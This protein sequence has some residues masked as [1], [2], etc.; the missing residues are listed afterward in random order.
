MKS[1]ILTLS[2]IFFPDHA[3]C[4][5]ATSVIEISLSSPHPETYRIE[6][7]SKEDY[8]LT[9]HVPWQNDLSKLISKK[10]VDYV[11]N[12]V[13]QIIWLSNYKS[14]ASQNCSEYASLVSGAD[15]ARVCTQNTKATARTYGLVA[16]LKKFK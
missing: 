8:R 14:G 16:S 5:T 11:T 15:H 12:E 10:P 13:T 1:F 4:V 9:H 3:F 6:K 2:I 7:T